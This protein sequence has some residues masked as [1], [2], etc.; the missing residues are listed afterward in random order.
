M[1]IKLSRG[2]FCKFGHTVVNEGKIYKL[3]ILPSGALRKNVTSVI[4]NG[5]AKE[6]ITSPEGIEFFVVD[7]DLK[8]INT[9]IISTA[10]ILAIL[11]DS[12]NH[13]RVKM[14]V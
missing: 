6:K 4:A 13:C 2:I 5:V 8:K 10:R 11:G 9:V 7:A 14:L 3:S 12:V 1:R